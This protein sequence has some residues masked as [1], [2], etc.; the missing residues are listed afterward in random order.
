[1]TPDTDAPAASSPTAPRFLGDVVGHDTA[2]DNDQ[3]KKKALIL[4]PFLFE[5]GSDPGGAVESMLVGTRDYRPDSGGQ[6]VFRIRNDQQPAVG[7]GRPTPEDFLGW[8]AYD[9]VLVHTHGAEYA[10][11]PTLCQALDPYFCVS[12][13]MTGRRVTGCLQAKT[14]Y[15]VYEGITC[16]RTSSGAQGSFVV[17]Q[18]EFFHEAYGSVFG[19]SGLDKAIVIMS[20]CHSSANGSLAAALAGSNSEFFGWSNVADNGLAVAGITRLVE[21]MV[22]D[23]LR[24][25]E[26]YQKL[27]NENGDIAGLATL[28]YRGHGNGLHIR[29]ITTLK[30]PISGSPSPAPGLTSG[31][32][33]QGAPGDVELTGGD[34]IPFVGQAGDNEPDELFFFVDIDGVESGKE[35]EFELSIELD[36]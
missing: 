5:L 22:L 28:E 25:P 21:L 14:I 34:V 2:R 30:N 1:M 10:D 29:E 9:F 24:T 20:A 18:T 17:L 35:G 23:G 7:S 27:H 12:G 31:A 15:S 16:G 26:A 6:R 4:S 13:V 19:S 8:T 11:N 36:D 33:P 3:K 32:G